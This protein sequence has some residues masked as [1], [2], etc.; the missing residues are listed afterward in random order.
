MI[1]H[2]PPSDADVPPYRDHSPVG[3]LVAI[4]I[5]FAL[6]LLPWLPVVTVTILAIG[7]IAAVTVR[8]VALDGGSTLPRFDPTIRMPGG[9]SFELRFT[10]R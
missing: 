6:T 9:R 8:R 5:L 2:R 7:L 4:T 10:T 1:G 3:G